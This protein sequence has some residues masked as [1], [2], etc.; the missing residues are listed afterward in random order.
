MTFGSHR[1]RGVDHP[2]RHI[3]PELASRMRPH[4]ANGTELVVKEIRRLFPEFDVPPHSD[5]GRRLAQGV[6]LAVERFWD[7]V[8]APGSPREPLLDRFRDLGRGELRDG[9]N[10]DALQSALRVGS[11]MSFRFLTDHRETLGIS[12]DTLFRIADAIFFHMDELA[13]ASTEGYAEARAQRSE[14]LDRQRGRLVRLL[15]NE[16]PAPPETIAH[17]AR[18]LGWHLPQTAAAV[19]VA[20]GEDSEPGAP[21]LPPDVLTDV[22]WLDA[23]LVM[24]D[25]DGPGRR[26]VL[27]AA[28]SGRIAAIGPTVPLSRLPLSLRYAQKAL[29]L[30]QRGILDTSALIRCSDHLVVLALFADRDLL[31]VLCRARL[32]PLAA[33]PQA[34]AD[35]LAETLL[36]WLR[37]AHNANRVAEHLYVHPQ[38]VRYRLRR[39]REL[40]GP[41]LDDA[42]RRFELQIALYARALTRAAD[43]R[44]RDPRA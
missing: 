8:E 33:L 20:D 19:V 37:H 44:T 34:Q 16:P 11:R 9:R 10:L 39:V 23:H 4:L 38:T 2:A 30:G 1:G 3:P 24:P 13:V 40:F 18:V 43:A 41:D 29:E 14:E 32:A 12:P 5:L 27:D 21:A 6:T 28:L 17:H 26:H 7:L 42:E 22:T 31:D 25:P 15:L 36:S 35:R